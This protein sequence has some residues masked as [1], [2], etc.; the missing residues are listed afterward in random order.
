MSYHQPPSFIEVGKHSTIKVS[1]SLNYT[2]TIKY[3]QIFLQKRN[4]FSNFSLT[5][6]PIFDGPLIHLPSK[7][8]LDAYIT[9]VYD[10]EYEVKT[11]VFNRNLPGK[12]AYVVD[13]NCEEVHFV[14]VL[15]IAFKDANQTERL[16]LKNEEI[17]SKLKN[18][19]SEITKDMQ[20]LTTS[21][22][23]LEY[24]YTK[25][26]VSPD[27][28]IANI[29]V[30]TDN[31]VVYE[32]IANGI[33]KLFEIEPNIAEF[34][35][36]LKN[37]R[38]DR[39]MTQSELAKK[40]GL[41][42]STIGMYERAEREPDFET[43]E[44][45]SDFFS[46]NMNTLLGK[47]SAFSVGKNSIGVKIPVL[48]KVAAG[49]P[50]TAVENIL[51]YEEIPAG[52]ASCGDYVALKIEGSSMEPRMYQ[53][54][55][56][57][58]RVQNTVEHGEVAVVMVGGSEATVKKV[59]FKKDGILLQPFNPSYEPI[60]YTSAEVESI[61]VQIFGKVVECRQKY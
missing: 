31:K 36:V 22:F 48:G 38:K 5:L 4:Y 51:D 39:Q 60:F 47:E 26:G 11:V 46:V 10:L 42:A 61:P 43:L 56:V 2:T 8:N 15:N 30:E 3:Q 16:V 21:S 50:I 14:P 32:E 23:K 35:I 40:L 37:L 9:K 49:I 1:P 45:I 58:V 54:D 55:I 59:Q 34:N 25:F 27:T 18:K 33:K 44:K 6:I 41:A 52:M 13:I 17:N 24:E 12:Y 29:S 53:G 19:F 28:L 20:V 7:S 57:I